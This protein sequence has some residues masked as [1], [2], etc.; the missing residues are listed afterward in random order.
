VAGSITKQ[1]WK[2]LVLKKFS[3]FFMFE[4]VKFL[5]IF[6]SDFLGFVAIF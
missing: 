3:F 1:K 6:F 4:E 5:T 2:K